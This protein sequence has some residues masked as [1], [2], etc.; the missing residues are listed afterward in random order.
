MKGTLEDFANQH[1]ATFL[2]VSAQ[3]NRIKSVDPMEAFDTCMAY[4]R[5][6]AQIIAQTCDSDEEF[7]ASM[8][9]LNRILQLEGLTVRHVMRGEA[10]AQASTPQ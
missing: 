6:F 9:E 10:K 2:R 5:C 8:T 1:T 4:T 7:V 3:L